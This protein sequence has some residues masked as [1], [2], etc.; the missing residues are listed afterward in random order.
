MRK[1][2][3]NR[4]NK[5]LLRII[6][7]VLVLVFVALGIY[8]FTK[9]NQNS[10]ISPSHIKIIKE[11]NYYCQ[12]GLLKADYNITENT[13]NTVDLTLKDGNI[14]TLFQTISASGV[15]YE[16]GSIVFFSK[17]DNAYLTENNIKTYTNCVSGNIKF[18]KI[19]TSTSIFIDNSEIFSFSFPSEFVLSGGEIG[20]SQ[21]W[22]QQSTNLGLVLA[23]IVIP[24]E[25]IQST[26]FSE[27]KFTVG[28]SADTDAV[29]NCLIYNLGNS[30]STTKATINNH[31]FTK[32][33][34]AD[35]GA[36][37]FYETTTYRTIYNDECYAIEYTIHSTNIG[38]Y[39]PD[40]GIIEFDKVKIT[41]IFEKIVMSFN[42]L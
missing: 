22:A 18:D 10:V 20:Y 2:I 3:S 28:V 30:T 1:N 4:L 29:K 14:I 33:S 36:G 32:I 17:G 12:E 5:K 24:R 8:I 6:V 27:A 16:L 41:E 7:I 15:R 26:N 34:F 21:N 19:S 38:N 40:Q 11:V 25:F 39:S 42:F 23:Q 9:S 37:N 31:E 13:T 35:A